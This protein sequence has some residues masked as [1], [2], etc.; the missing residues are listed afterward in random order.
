MKLLMLS[1]ESLESFEAKIA[2]IN[3][4]ED[5]LGKAMFKAVGGLP[6]SCAGY[7]SG[8]PDTIDV[9][10]NDAGNY[11][12]DL[13]P[14]ILYCIHTSAGILE[15]CIKGSILFTG[16]TADGEFCDLTD[17]QI[18]AVKDSIASLPF[19]NVLM[20]GKLRTVLYA[21]MTANRKTRH[22]K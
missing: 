19:S 6:S 18:G 1:P 16:R 8:M 12:P 14:V 2:E 3:C 15:G 11:I 7:I 10:C 4:S 22:S 5:E 20:D 17:E 21:D 13:K 9:W